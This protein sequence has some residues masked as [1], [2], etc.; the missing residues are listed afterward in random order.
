VTEWLVIAGIV[1]VAI[2][3]AACATVLLR[4]VR[5]E[6]GAYFNALRAATAETGEAQGKRLASIADQISTQLD[7]L[8]ALRQAMAKMDEKLQREAD[9]PSDLT[10]LTALDVFLAANFREATT[11]DAQRSGG[12]NG[13][14]SVARLLVLEPPLAK[15]V[16]DIL[17]AQGALF[18]RL[19]YLSSMLE[20]YAVLAKLP[21][22][23]M[24]IFRMVGFAT[25]KTPGLQRARELYT[26]AL[27]ADRDHGFAAF[28]LAGIAALEQSPDADELYQRAGRSNAFL[29]AHAALR[30]AAIKERQEDWAH[31]AELYVEAAVGLG[32]IGPWHENA[33]RCMRRAGRAEE[34]LV[35]YERAL[36]WRLQPG[37]EFT[38]HPPTPRSGNYAE[39]LPSLLRQFVSPR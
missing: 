39:T 26:A 9:H 32:H 17:V 18:H 4:F 22:E 30:R 19:H 8:N 33:G 37:A 29:R 12:L 3:A 23:D 6:A 25:G 10:A 15:G 38:T 36:E 35:H 24:P 14:L 2:A 31:A 7:A 20:R 11:E 21:R 34:A 28:N 16:A 5:S 13:H 27:A 1:L